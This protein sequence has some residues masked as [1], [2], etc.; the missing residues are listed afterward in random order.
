M[1]KF[2]TAS[3][4]AL[5][6]AALLSDPASAQA[7]S[8]FCDTETIQAMAPK[9]TTIAFAA[10]ES[11]GCMVRGYVTTRDPGPNKVLFLIALPNNFNGRYLYVGVGGSG[12]SLPSVPQDLYA[13]GYAVAGSDGGSGAKNGSDF[14]FM[15]DPAR[16]LDFAWRGVHVS[17]QATQQLV[18]AYYKRP[19]IRRYA[20]GCSGGG[21]MG[22]TNALRF[23]SEDFEGVIVGATPL[24]GSPYMPNA[25][26]IIQYVQTHPE[27]WIS[28][29]LLQKADAAILARYDAV[30]GAKDGIISDQRD[31]ANFDVGILRQVGFTPAQIETF[32]QIR[33]AHKFTLP[34]RGQVEME[35]YPITNVASWSTF[36]LGRS[37]PPWPSVA[38]SSPS[39]VAMRGAPYF[40]MMADTMTRARQPDTFYADVK[41]P[42]DLTRLALATAESREE[43]SYDKLAG[44]GVKLFIYHGVNDEADSYLDTL[45]AYNT[46]AAKYPNHAQWLRVLPIAGLMHCVGG[47]GPTDVTPPLVEA[48][49][50]W[51]E[52]A[53]PPQSIDMHRRTRDG[54]LE[55]TFRVCAEPYRVALKARGLDPKSAD[56]WICRA[57]GKP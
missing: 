6:G 8:E 28:P 30:D 19:T 42:E 54:G 49:V 37:A 13:Q 31:I 1:R 34:G 45:V 33:L 48:M 11:G 38:T 9:D 3:I 52:K 29:D 56:S 17:A 32:N 23:G 24:L 5:A 15:S 14:G 12:G 40:H 18:K 10:R 16:S 26:R 20:T 35:G 51:V 43:T 53:T 44:S 21:Q 7:P 47:T 36:M 25:Y 27:G 4:A 46:L 2:I 22:L 41:S 39:Q 57:P 55:R 50:N